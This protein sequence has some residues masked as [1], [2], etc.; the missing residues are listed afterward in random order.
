MRN[1]AWLQQRGRQ[2]LME[3]MVVQARGSMVCHHTHYCIVFACGDVS[4]C[5]FFFWVMWMS[6]LWVN[7]VRTWD[8]D[9]CGLRFLTHILPFYWQQPS[10]SAWCCWIGVPPQLSQHLGH[11]SY[12]PIPT[13]MNPPHIK[14]SYLVMHIM[15]QQTPEVPLFH[16]K[17]PKQLYKE[18]HPIS[19]YVCLRLR[20][21]L[22]F[23]YIFF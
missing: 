17:L 7:V 10:A 5:A 21:F 6:V 12:K 22:H 14:R 2:F 11:T 23:V 15:N 8:G 13:P 1:Q 9:E 19:K 16:L 3:W 18:W 20:L 4:K